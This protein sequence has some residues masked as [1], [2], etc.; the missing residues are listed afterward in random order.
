MMQ[1]ATQEEEGRLK[2]E[3]SCARQARPLNS[4][5][6][7]SHAPD[8][9]MPKLLS[10][11]QITPGKPLDPIQRQELVKLQ[12]HIQAQ[13]KEQRMIVEKYKQIPELRHSGLFN[14]DSLATA[15][16]SA[17]SEDMSTQDLDSSR[18][19]LDDPTQALEDDS[20]AKP[21]ILRSERTTDSLLGT[22]TKVHVDF[23]DPYLSDEMTRDELSSLVDELM[24][25]GGI[26]GEDTGEPSIESSRMTSK[27]TAKSRDCFSSSRSE[28]LNDENLEHLVHEDSVNEEFP[29]SSPATS[30][31]EPYSSSKTCQRPDE[32][33]AA[34]ARPVIH[35]EMTQIV[36][37][38]D[39]TLEPADLS[40][41]GGTPPGRE[42]RRLI[43]VA[44]RRMFHSVGTGALNQIVEA[45]REWKLQP[46]TAIVKQQ[47]PVNTGP[48]LCVLLEGVVDVIHRPLGATSNEKVCTYDRCGQCFGELEL[49]YDVPKGTGHERRLHW[50]TIATRTPV[51]L[52]TIH[53]DTLRGLAKASSVP[54]KQSLSEASDSGDESMLSHRTR[55]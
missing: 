46:C 34:L 28:D 9:P 44:V 29:V 16:P 47:S 18:R 49:L 55:E 8:M 6:G 24:K 12:Q 25:R 13:L 22:T 15:A 17:S 14:S 21:S 10:L 40:Q 48:G 2:H 3:R 35:K 43:E 33:S 27:A 32:F 54:C 51:T 50:A 38:I 52:W 5:H 19:H 45:F 11:P 31:T 42:E 53:R 36:A 39:R 20:E 37:P 4:R 30:S 1:A 7:A 41:L 23:G 26:D